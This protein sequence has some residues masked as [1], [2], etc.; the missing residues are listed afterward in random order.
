MLCFY[1]D[2]SVLRILWLVYFNSQQRID[3][4]CEQNDCYQTFGTMM[5]EKLQQ[6]L[7]MNNWFVCRFLLCVEI[8]YMYQRHWPESCYYW[9][10]ETLA[11]LNKPIFNQN[12]R[13]LDTERILMCNYKQLKR[14]W[15]SWLMDHL[16]MIIC[17]VY[18]QCVFKW[19]YE[20]LYIQIHHLWIVI[21][22]WKII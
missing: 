22:Q 4:K 20:F 15:I 11:K 7:I 17:L 12:K 10:C 14:Y 1:V 9:T 5:A 13:P 2:E 8:V 6:K 16:K 21:I 3:L 19:N 18:S